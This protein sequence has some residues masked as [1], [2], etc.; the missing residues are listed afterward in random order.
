MPVEFTPEELVSA[1]E[2]SNRAREV[3]LDEHPHAILGSAKET[4]GLFQFS[5]DVGGGAPSD[6]AMNRIK[7]SFLK[8]EEGI[9][10]KTHQLK[11]V[12]WIVTK[13]QRLRDFRRECTVL[14]Y[15]GVVLVAIGVVSMIRD[16]YRMF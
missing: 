13:K 12:Y 7:P 5:V 1:H 15:V 3:I 9:R 2:Q 8:I 11:D 6:R 16:E 10:D 14:F 4:A